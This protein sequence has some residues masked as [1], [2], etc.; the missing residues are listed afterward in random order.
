MAKATVEAIALL[1]EFGFEFTTA[2]QVGEPTPARIADR[3]TEIIESLEEARS[4]GDL[5]GVQHVADK[6]K[7]LQQA[8]DV[9]SLL[10]GDLDDDEPEAE[11][12]VAAPLP[13]NAGASTAVEGLGKAATVEG[14][15]LPAITPET[16]APSPH[17]GSDEKG[18][19]NRR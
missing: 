5:K 17:P 11:A 13:T 14:Q 1:G 8:I 18:S 15:W 9:W 6:L 12:P 2:D 16:T 10:A 3:L 7:K 4:R 19:D